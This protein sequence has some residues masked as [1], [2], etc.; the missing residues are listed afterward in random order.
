[1]ASTTYRLLLIRL[2]AWHPRHTTNQYFHD[3]GSRI[4]PR[5]PCPSAWADYHPRLVSQRS[6]LWYCSG[7]MDTGL[8]NHP[9]PDDP[10]VPEG[11]A[12]GSRD[13][14]EGRRLKRIAADARRLAGPAN[15]PE[16][17][18]G[19]IPGPGIGAGLAAA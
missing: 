10:A 2:V 4:L 15:R 12:A 17:R 14:R 19:G 18:A 5:Q 13:G 11:L 1:M 3:S 8:K 7:A 6:E 9:L 16:S